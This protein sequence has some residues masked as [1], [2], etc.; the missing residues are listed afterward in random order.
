MPEQP[1]PGDLFFEKYCELNG[2]TWDWQPTCNGSPPLDYL[3]DRA[4][5]QAVVEVKYFTTR[6]QHEKLKTMPGKAMF[7]QST[8]PNLQSRIRRGAEQLGPCARLGLPLV[9]VLTTPWRPTSTS[10]ATT[11]LRLCSAR[12]STTSISTQ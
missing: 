12:R 4:G 7:M 11:W 2:Y 3:V 8:V 10:I 6:W 1:T 5:D 9:V